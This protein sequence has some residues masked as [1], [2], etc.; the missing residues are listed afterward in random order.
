MVT[1]EET[2]AMT[3]VAITSMEKYLFA[4]SLSP[5]PMVLPTMAEPPAPSIKPRE[6]II[7]TSG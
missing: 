4:R 6:A 3:I 7:C 1:A 2:V 5:S